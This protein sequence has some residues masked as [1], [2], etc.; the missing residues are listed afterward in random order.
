MVPEILST[1]DQIFCYFGIIFALLPPKNLKIQNFEKMKN[2][3]NPP[4]KK[5]L[6]PS[7]GGGGVGIPPTSQRYLENPEVY[8]K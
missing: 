3:A 6:P 2:R 5:K 8:H 1:T 4:S 7:R